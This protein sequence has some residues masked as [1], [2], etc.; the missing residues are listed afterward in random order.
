MSRRYRV[1]VLQIE[2]GSQ[3]EKNLEKVFSLVESASS[4]RPDFIVLPE[5]FEIVPAPDEAGRFARPIPDGLTE[6]LSEAAKGC[7]SN[8]VAGSI[9]ERDGGCLYN[10]S[11]IFDRNGALAGRYRKVHLFD[12][13]SYGESMSLTGG[14]EPTVFTLDGL[15]FGV[16]VC[17]DVRFPEL[18]R[19]YAIEGARVVFVPS[20]FFQPNHDH[21]ELA[22]RARALDNGF[23]VVGC[24]QTGRRFVGRSMAADPWGIPVASM[25]TG[26]GFFSVDIDTSV[27]EETR[28]KLPL[29][30]NRRFDVSLRGPRPCR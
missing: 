25:G 18:F 5:M 26:E 3:P 6:R 2:T 7:S 14:N 9:I 30:E 24:C 10:T 27:V 20:A 12:A 8:L 21:W 16:A 23:Y 22:V 29:L 1:C 15:R 17:Y 4:V 28:K 19:R 11:A 13:F